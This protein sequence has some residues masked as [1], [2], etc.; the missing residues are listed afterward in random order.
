MKINEKFN[1]VKDLNSWE[2]QEV[3]QNINPFTGDLAKKTSVTKSWFATLEQ[4][5]KFIYGNSIDL[6]NC[7]E[8]KDVF[9]EIVKQSTIIQKCIKES[10][11]FS[12]KA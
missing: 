5:F 9:N 10:Q 8:I 2:V 11:N 6:T 1:L 7:N 3:K 4:A 12:I